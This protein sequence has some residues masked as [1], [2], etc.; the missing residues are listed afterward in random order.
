MLYRTTIK[1][2]NN[3]PI[4]TWEES[5]FRHPKGGLNKFNT[6]MIL[7]YA[8]YNMIT[9]VFLVFCFKFALDANLNQGILSTLFGLTA[10]F[11]AVASY[12]LF[13]EKLKL[14][15]IIGM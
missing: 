10:F 2:Y 7:S 11:S 1:Y 8:A 12:F 13:N 6:A 15:H 4:W 14:A 5:Y 3:E 9:L